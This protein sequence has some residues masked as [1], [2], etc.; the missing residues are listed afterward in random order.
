MRYII[1]IGSQLEG[2]SPPALHSECVELVQ[3]VGNVFEVEVPDGCSG[4]FFLESDCGVTAS[5]AVCSESGSCGPCKTCV[6]GVCVD[7]CPKGCVED[8][9]VECTNNNQCI[10]GETCQNFQCIPPK[11]KVLGPDGYV[12]CLT[13]EHCKGCD[14]CD[15]GTCVDATPN[16]DDCSPTDCFDICDESSGEFVQCLNKDH[17]GENQTCVG[18]SCECLP[19]YRLNPAGECIVAETCQNQFD[20]GPCEV[21]VEGFCQPLVCPEGWIC[22]NGKCEK[23]CGT[24]ADCVVGDCVTVQGI[25]VCKNCK[26][27]C[28]DGGECEEGCT[29]V[30]KNCVALPPDNT[31]T[32]VGQCSLGFKCVGGICVEDVGCVGGCNNVSDCGVGCGCLEENC[33]DCSQIIC[34]TNTDCPQGCAC[35]GGNCGSVTNPEFGCIST[36]CA[37]STTCGPN[38]GCDDGVCVPCSTL[39]C[40]GDECSSVP[41]CGCVQGNC[42]QSVG[43]D[44][45]LQVEKIPGQ[46]QIQAVLNKDACCLC[47]QI[48]SGIKIVNVTGTAQKSFQ[49]EVRLK[50]TTLSGYNLAPLLGS[51]GITNELPSTGI[52][53]VSLVTTLR[54]VDN[55]GNLLNEAPATITVNGN[56]S[57]VNLGTTTLPFTSGNVG[58]IISHNG[59]PHRVM[60][61]HIYAQTNTV[62]FPS[63]CQRKLERKL[64]YLINTPNG[65]STAPQKVYELD[66]L[67]L[68]GL[69]LV[70]WYRSTVISGLFNQANFLEG[71]YINTHYVLPI[72]KT[73]A[74]RYYGATTNCG[75]AD[76]AIYSCIGNT[77]TKLTFCQP[78]DLDFTLS[79]CNK[80]LTFN[81]DVRVTCDPMK[82]SGMIY[83][84]Y[85]NGVQVDSQQVSLT[86]LIYPQGHVITSADTIEEVV[87]KM[88]DDYCSECEITKPVDFPTIVAELQLINRKCS[89]DPNIQAVIGP[90]SLS[91]YTL[92]VNGAQVAAGNTAETISLLPLS[93]VYK[94]TVTDGDCSDTVEKTLLVNNADMSGYYTLTPFCEDGVKKL[95][96]VTLLQMSV[97]VPAALFL[98][99]VNGT[100]TLVIPDG[101]VEV[102]M[103]LGG[104]CTTQNFVEADCCIP[105]PLDSLLLPT[106]SCETGLILPSGEGLNFLL[107]QETITNGAALP[108]G[109]TNITATNGICSKVLTFQVPTCYNCY[110]HLCAP[111]TLLPGFTTNACGLGCQI[112][113]PGNVNIDYNCTTGL[114][115][116]STDPAVDVYIGLQLVQ[117]GAIV[118]SGLTTFTIVE[119]GNN[120]PPYDVQRVIPQCY[121]CDPD[122]DL[123][124]PL[125][126]ENCCMPAI[127]N[128]G[129]SDCPEVCYNPPAT[130]TSCLKLT[131]TLLSGQ[132]Y[133]Y[134]VKKNSVDY[135]FS[136]PGLYNLSVLSNITRFIEDFTQAI[137]DEYP[138]SRATCF[139]GITLTEVEGN[140]VVTVNCMCSEEDTSGWELVTMQD[141]LLYEYPAVQTPCEVGPLDNCVCLHTDVAG[142]TI[143]GIFDINNYNIFED[144]LFT[145]NSYV[146]SNPATR[147]LLETQIVDYFSRDGSAC[148]VSADITYDS[149]TQTSTVVI[150]CLDT[151]TYPMPSFIQSG[152]ATYQSSYVEPCVCLEGEFP[153]TVCQNVNYVAEIPVANGDITNIVLGSGS[154]NVVSGFNFPYDVTNGASRA[155]LLSDLSTYFSDNNFFPCCEGD[156]E[157]GS[158]AY[159]AEEA[160]GIIPLYFG[161]FN[162]DNVSG[163]PVTVV[164]GVSDVLFNQEEPEFDCC[165]LF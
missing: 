39:L 103:S 131:M 153:P 85:F 42:V 83:D 62:N 123:E 22:V 111:G 147:V 16:C 161:C 107:G 87:L 57:L 148:E 159:F 48:V 100:Q 156:P 150:C 76:P 49:V 152:L 73:V 79:N 72:E 144:V 164:Q 81:Q 26:G 68:C 5:Y 64:V 158:Y 135:L 145:Q 162:L 33:V 165:I 2:A 84:L 90:A 132:I 130:C 80:V 118:A 54:K 95:T 99:I 114:D 127:P 96:I 29:C 104:A 20:C 63:T 7:K 151:G 139:E 109:T 23:L 94:L 91:S 88:R 50:K 66:N 18:K 137:S 12:D 82:K 138:L 97:H 1:T 24:N 143:T 86:G 19:G 110:G 71:R 92:E 27:S 60:S 44:D 157:V 4:E 142:A 53:S 124:G 77:P 146:V 45:T 69:P 120:L 32:D 154:L 37:N 149:L 67:N 34:N 113:T 106:Y 9:C 31:C 160:E 43:C 6:N 56:T 61:F 134:G 155:Q 38:C 133:V 121:V 93:G 25:K 89:L 35:N 141:E 52:F 98:G 75:C 47:E 65:L 46:C 59:Q 11:D 15:E 108:A 41:G 17:C 30:E 14:I 36:L 21:C 116:S 10:P 163:A 117:S 122:C 119:Y 102:V 140:Y 55:L 126:E 28:G 101:P 125:P 129:Y 8:T 40:S 70:K 105:N 78:D 58:E 3:S 74:G 112:V 13:K 115:I 136:D 128:L 51:T